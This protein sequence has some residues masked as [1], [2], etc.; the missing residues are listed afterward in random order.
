MGNNTLTVQ[1]ANY[2]NTTMTSCD[3]GYKLGN[4]TAFTE[5]VTFSPG[6]TTGQSHNHTYS[7]ALNIPSSGTYTLKIWARNPNGVG[8]DG[9]VNNDTIT[10]TVC[11][12]MSGAYTINPSGA[13]K[14][15]NFYGCS[16]RFEF[17]WCSWCV[18]FYSVTR[19]L[20]REVHLG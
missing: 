19:Y 11:T 17:L 18:L 13:I 16:Q 4:A 2:G 12:G 5:N 6:K 14:L 8:P 15:H 7:T 20:Y 9:N 1:I 3:I 10:T